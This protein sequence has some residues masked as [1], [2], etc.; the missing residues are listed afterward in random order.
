MYRVLTTLKSDVFPFYIYFYYLSWNYCDVAL[1]IRLLQ[2]I[3]TRMYVCSIL[4]VISYIL[5][6]TRPL[7]FRPDFV[8]GENVSNISSFKVIQNNDTFI[9]MK[10]LLVHL[11]NFEI[12]F[13]LL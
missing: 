2:C 5:Y 10:K 3:E 1:R 7:F 4:A 13:K 9:S 11:Q 6:I 12:I 8:Y